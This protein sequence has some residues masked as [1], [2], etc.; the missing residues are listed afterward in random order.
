MVF[1]ETL[2]RQFRRWVYEATKH[3]EPTRLVHRISG[4][5]EMPGA[6]IDGIESMEGLLQAMG[7]HE[8]TR[9]GSGLRHPSVDCTQPR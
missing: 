2:R 4:F 9:T 8:S 5:V 7:I 3:A 6:T 1:K